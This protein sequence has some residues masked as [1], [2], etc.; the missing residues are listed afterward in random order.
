MPLWGFVS[1]GGSGVWVADSSYAYYINDPASP[2]SIRQFDPSDES[3][4]VIALESDCDDGYGTPGFPTWQGR[5]VLALFKGNLYALV[6]AA[7]GLDYQGQLWKWDGT[8][9]N[10]TKVHTNSNLGNSRANFFLYYDQNRM[11]YGLYD[12]VYWTDDGSSFNGPGEVVDGISHGNDSIP[13]VPPMEEGIRMGM[14]HIPATYGL[15]P[16]QMIFQENGSP[17]PYHIYTFNPTSGDWEKS[18]TNY[19]D[20]ANSYPNIHCAD[21]NFIW[22]EK[23]SIRE[24]EYTTDRTLLSG[25][26]FTSPSVDDIRPCPTFGLPG[27]TIGT[28]ESGALPRSAYLWDNDTN[29]WEASADGLI[30]LSGSGGARHFYGVMKFADNGGETYGFVNNTGT[31]GDYIVKRAE[32]LPDIATGPTFWAGVGTL[33][34][35]CS[36][37]MATGP[38]PQ[39]MAVNDNE[40]EVVIL[41]NSASGTVFAEKVVAA[42]DYATPEDITDGLD[43]QAYN[44]ADYT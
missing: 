12:S 21:Y 1:A 19:G 24:Y 8:P 36:L 14:T 22:R 17:D 41:N 40:D 10:W 27:Y 33:A 18:Y 13:Q 26:T 30:F 35:K 37:N 25:S 2:S 42:D 34:Q 31:G 9:N 11:V 5:N 44:A 3:I 6:V 28:I 29:E 23:S 15:H 32:T 16:M 4:T 43:S 38:A 7:S 39:G 20:D